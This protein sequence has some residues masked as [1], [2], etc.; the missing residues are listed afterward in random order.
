MKRSSQQLYANKKGAESQKVSDR[1]II[2]LENENH[3]FYS[4][5]MRPFTIE[6][7]RHPFVLLVGFQ[8][9]VKKV[10]KE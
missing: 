2:R 5:I 7:S 1:T 6:F 10:I 9:A 4:N 3:F 8:S